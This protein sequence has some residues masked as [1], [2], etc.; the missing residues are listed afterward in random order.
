[1]N[2]SDDEETLL[3]TKQHHVL[4]L[5]PIRSDQ[6][7]FPKTETQCCVEAHLPS[8]RENLTPDYISFTGVS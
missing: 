1:M 5:N 6:I 4:L 7:S 3:D 8:T 2:N